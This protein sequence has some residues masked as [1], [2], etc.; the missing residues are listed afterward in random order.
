MSTLEELAAALKDAW[1]WEDVE[2]C[3]Q[4]VDGEWSQ[5]GKYQSRVSVLLYKGKHFMLQE[6]RSG[7][8]HSDWYYGDSYLHEVE[9]R[10]ETK[11][12]VSW[13]MPTGAQQLTIKSRD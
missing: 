4:V 6:S 7:S 9:R 1:S 13:S 10:E 8:Y 5:D 3:E 2:G 11:V 12:V